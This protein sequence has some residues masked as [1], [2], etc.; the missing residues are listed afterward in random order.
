MPFF[1]R[2]GHRR[3]LFVSRP[4]YANAVY[5]LQIEFLWSKPL[6]SVKCGGPIYFV[7]LYLGMKYALVSI[8]QI[9][10]VE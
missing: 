4:Q 8:N 2:I 1:I 6:K 5:A 9:R 3:G 7:D 10:E